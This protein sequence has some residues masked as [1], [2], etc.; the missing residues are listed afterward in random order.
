[1]SGSDAASLAYGYRPHYSH[2]E[3]WP[4]PPMP[5]SS[6][7]GR[8]RE[9]LPPSLEASSHA[10]AQTRPPRGSVMS[11]ITVAQENPTPIELSLRGPRH[12]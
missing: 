10:P 3:P 6:V 9:T 12:G 2:T 5:E 8:H 4:S 7:A 1:M 11:T